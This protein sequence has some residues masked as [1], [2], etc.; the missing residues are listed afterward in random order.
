M[1]ALLSTF[2]LLA[3]A[4]TILTAIVTALADGGQPR[5]DGPENPG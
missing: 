5:D 3:V 4:G 1:G 2:I